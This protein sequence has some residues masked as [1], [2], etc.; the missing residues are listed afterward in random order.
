MFQC[1]R[2]WRPSAPRTSRGT[3]SRH[4]LRSS[5]SSSARTAFA[6][7]EIIS[8]Q[9]ASLRSVENVIVVPWKLIR[10]RRIPSACSRFASPPRIPFT[11]RST[12]IQSITAEVGHSAG[13][14][15]RLS[16]IAGFA[17]PRRASA[18]IAATFRIA[19]SAVGS[20]ERTT[21]RPATKSSSPFVMRASEASGI[22]Q[23]ASSE[24]ASAY[25]VSASSPSIQSDGK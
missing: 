9:S 22:G 19:R 8:H 10:A 6:S 18:A 16:S 12:P 13:S 5:I 21:I 2:C 7:G 20:A 3:S 25:A 4:A 1:P 17:A 24:I 15:A 11:R 14:I 23:P